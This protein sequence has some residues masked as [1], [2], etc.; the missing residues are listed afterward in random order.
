ME[1][2]TV[3]LWSLSPN[4]YHQQGEFIYK[5]TICDLEIEGGY[6][7]HVHILKWKEKVVGLDHLANL[8]SGYLPAFC[9]AEK[10]CSYLE[11]MGCSPRHHPS[12]TCL[13]DDKDDIR[14]R[15]MF[16]NR[17]IQR[18]ALLKVGKYKSAFFL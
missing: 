16:E 11:L 5:E 3:A 13:E 15:E 18:E 8:I 14:H 9:W 1:I 17:H 6:A 7:C 10:K 12:G 4:P 2:G